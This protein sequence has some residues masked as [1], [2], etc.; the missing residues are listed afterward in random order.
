MVFNPTIAALREH[1]GQ[2]E[3]AG[4]DWPAVS[5]G[6]S[7]L[8]Q[9]LPQNGLA[10]G[11][12]Y[13]MVPDQYADFPATLG[14]GLGVLSRILQ[15]Q[16]GSVLWVQTAHQALAETT[17]YPIGLTSFGIDPNRIIHVKVPKAQHA[18]WA[19]DEA[20]ANN[21]ISTVVGLFGE[22]EAAYDFTAVRRL[23]MRAASHGTTAFILLR[24]PCFSMATAADMRW[25][26]ASVPSF[27]RHRK[28]Q[29]IACPDVPRWHLHLSKSRSGKPGQW[30]IEWNHET[31]SFRMAAP[32]ADRAKIRLSGLEAQ[33]P[34]AA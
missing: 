10:T 20:L 12:L 7:G 1:I 27:P 23:S 25:R 3:K 28:G 19:L 15:Q 31:L 17:L 32:L 6:T 33:Q 26:I 14:F 2:Q 11:A 18:L 22:D 21:A 9:A 29:A 30:S 16:S 4:H 5:L 34:V 13:E 24:D 8:D